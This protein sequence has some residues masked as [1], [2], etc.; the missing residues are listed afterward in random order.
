MKSRY[1][2][3]IIGA[4]IFLQISV[5]ADAP[6][7]IYYPQVLEDHQWSMNKEHGFYCILSNPV[8]GLGDL[9]L[10]A[11]AG[12]VEQIAVAPDPFQSEHRQVSVAIT[13]PPWSVTPQHM[14]I[15]NASIPAGDSLSIDIS[16]VNVL[17]AFHAGQQ[18]QLVVDDN[19]GPSVIVQ[20]PA[21]NIMPV[22]EQFYRCMDDLLL[23]NFEQAKHNTFY[24][25]SGGKRLDDDQRQM[26]LHIAEYVVADHN[27]DRIT[28]DSHTDSYGDEL[29]NRELSKKRGQLLVSE[30]QKIGVPA[31]KILMR[32][33]GERYPVADNNTP[34]GRNRNRRVEIRITR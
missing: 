20:V 33:H 3:V 22:L 31:G 29:V 28:I 25:P 26:L 9:Q 34:D 27:V 4:V 6:Q 19:N 10:I 5:F 2:A 16:M 8:A 17:K 32:F 23:L 30:L 21:L 24:Y 14:P 18:L 13:S 12:E 7:T 11:E 15:A 1:A